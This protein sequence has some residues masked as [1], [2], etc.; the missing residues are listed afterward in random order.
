MTNNDI[1]PK[2]ADG[3]DNNFDILNMVQA[4]LIKKT[5][6]ADP[7]LALEIRMGEYK[8]VVFSFS[9][10]D[11]LPVQMEGGFVPTKYE[12]TI[13]KIPPHFPKGW[14]QT[15]AFDSFTT[16][17]L[18]KWLSYIHLNDMGPL[19]AARTSPTIQ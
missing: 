9:K 17:I 19:L 8:G 3:E 14:K 13:H 11:V 18:F 4:C 10:F 6:F 16:E 1:R 12:T 5:P 2:M 7:V 15:V